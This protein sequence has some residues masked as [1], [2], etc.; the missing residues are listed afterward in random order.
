ME[1]VLWGAG[2]A[3]DGQV[4]ARW[5]QGKQVAASDGGVVW[6]SKHGN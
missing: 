6:T 3:V 4:E 2:V 1:N 5:R